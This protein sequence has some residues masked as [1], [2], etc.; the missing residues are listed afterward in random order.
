MSRS[1]LLTR[2]DAVL[3]ERGALTFD[4]L[5]EALYPTLER[6]VRTAAKAGQPGSTTAVSAALRRGGYLVT[7]N[8]QSGKR[9]VYP[10]FDLAVTAPVSGE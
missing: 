2:I 6:G 7:G 9:V 10:R 5:T 1:T 3:G 8:F 4:E